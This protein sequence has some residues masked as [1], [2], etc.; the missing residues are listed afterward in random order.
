MAEAVYA[1]CALTS[2]A[3]AVLLYRAYRRQGVG[4]LFW[5]VICFAALAANNI[6]LFI[7]LVIVPDVDLRA[8]RSG[9]AVVG[10]GS[11]LVSFIRDSV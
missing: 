3:C 11:L 8:L 1:L 2:L 6:V 7:D 4:L 5:S 9:I 10:M